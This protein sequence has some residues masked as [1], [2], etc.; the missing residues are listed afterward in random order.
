MLDW[1]LHPMDCADIVMAS[2]REQ[3]TELHIADMYSRDR[4]SPLQD[5]WLDGE[6][7]LSSAYGLARDGRMV[8]MFRR[9]VPGQNFSKI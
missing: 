1:P 8:V 5:A 6:E 3:S 4:S 2:V 7:S 9:M